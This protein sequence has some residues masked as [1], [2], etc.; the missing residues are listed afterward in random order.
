MAYAVRDRMLSRSLAAVEAISHADIDAK[1]VAYLS[2]EFLTG[3][4]LGNGLVNLGIWEAAED[5]LSR[6]GQRLATIIEEEEEPGL[7]HSG[8]GLLAASCL[9]SLATLNVPA[10]GYGI[11]YEFGTFRQA[12]RDGWQ[13]EMTDKWL[14][15]G[16]PW[17]IVRSDVVYDV[18]LGGYTS[19]QTDEDGQYRVQWHA[20]KMV[21]GVAYDTPV[22]GFRVPATG[23]LRLWKA[24]ATES[25]DFEAFDV[26]D[27]YRAT[28]EKV[29][30]EAISKVLYPCDE[31]EAGRRLRLAQQY[32]LVSCSLQ[33]MLRLH[34]MRGK[35]LQDL[36][37]GWAAHINDTAPAIAIAE[38][39]HLLVDEHRLDWEQAWAITQRTFACTNHALRQE[40][41][42]TWPVM[43]LE[44]LLPRHL[45]VVFEINRRFLDDVRRRFGGDE[46]LIQRL[47]LID[48]SGERRVRMAHLA[49]VGSHAVNGV[50]VL[51]THRLE[52]TVLAD[53]HRVA[54]EKFLTVTSGVT[55]RRWLVLCNPGLTALIARHIGTRWIVDME[56]EIGLLESLADDVDFQAAWQAVK[57][58]NKRALAGVI[59]ER[60]G[61]VVD[62]HSL[63]DVHVDRVQE[64]KRQHLGVLD[65]IARYNRILRGRGPDDVPR[66]YV[67]GGRAAPTSRHGKL[68]IKL[69]H[70]VAEVVNANRTS[71]D[72]LRV[73]FLPDFN[74]KNG[75]LVY[76]AA[77]ISEQIAM[78]G[79]DASAT[80][81]IAFGMNG[82]LTIGTPG[83]SNVEI[84]DAVGY[85]N[86]FLFGLAPD[87]AEQLRTSRYDPRRTYESNAALREALGMIADGTFSRGNRN[88]FRPLLE[89]LL[90]HD[91]HLVLA[92]FAA[93]AES[94]QRVGEAFAS[95]QAWTRMSILNTA[96]I[97]RFSSD[98][99]V[100]QYCRDVWNVQ[101]ITRKGSASWA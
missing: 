23:L 44:T 52:E 65:I 101:P 25:S 64:H 90:A 17:E 63:F 20:A 99:A 96:R 48:E 70:S 74:V 29:I 54:P 3:P 16:N 45:E 5:A 32:F 100:R 49:T 22:P 38:L 55:Q 66:T 9:D 85:E 4:H 95:G 98:R 81:C 40:A 78:A 28:D 47:S 10:V 26:G 82:G 57:A 1:M 43:L 75:Q 86:F 87:E 53:F 21:R 7:G 2:T 61:V 14:R 77:D 71:A 88:L 97:G 76:A 30:S 18:K 19:C 92:D 58:D 11:R 89:P 31:P 35:R 51:H 27:Y 36:H 6:F 39:M 80:G 8:L 68:M 42:E 67:F 37:L 84:R 60:T 72:Q 79:A 59:R 56:G 33:D 12:I 15:S 46:P 41:L 93:Y 94:Q 50:S 24:E 73:V 13:V 69:I 91:E 83:W 62:P 34:L